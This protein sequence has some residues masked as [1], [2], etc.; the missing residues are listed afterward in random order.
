MVE[1]CSV[2]RKHLCGMK[3]TR[4]KI[5]T[6]N[7]QSSLKLIVFYFIQY[8]DIEIFQLNYVLSTIKGLE[9]TQR[10]NDLNSFGDRKYVHLIHISQE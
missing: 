3:K 7:S 9:I 6:K 5:L 4:R 10:W 2:T 1:F 8:Y